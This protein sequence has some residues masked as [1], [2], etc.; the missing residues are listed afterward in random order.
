MTAEMRYTS[1]HVQVVMG[2][3]YGD[4][5]YSRTGE[6]P[7]GGVCFIGSTIFGSKTT[8]DPK[9]NPVAAVDLGML[10]DE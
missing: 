10:G 9:L 6:L 8:F 3:V 4:L 7:R 2:V 1:G 5:V